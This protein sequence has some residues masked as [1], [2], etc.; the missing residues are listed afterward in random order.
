MDHAIWDTGHWDNCRWDDTGYVPAVS[1]RYAALDKAIFDY[2]RWDYFRWNVYIPDW[3]RVLQRFKVIP[4]QSAGAVDP[5]VAA[6]FRAGM[7]RCQVYIPYFDQLKRRM[8]QAS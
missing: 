1:P 7:F 4:I 3:E 5:C 2:C 6:G 8:Q